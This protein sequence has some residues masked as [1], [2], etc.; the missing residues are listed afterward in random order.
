MGEEPPFFEEAVR[1]VDERLGSQLGG[2]ITIS[3][4]VTLDRPLID[5]V[6]KIDNR[7]FR[8]DLRYTVWDMIKRGE[9][10][11]FFLMMVREGK[12]P[13]AFFFGYE[14]DELPG[15]FYGDDMASVSEGKG[16]GG[17]LFTL[18]HIYCYENGYTHFSCHAE[19]VDDKGRRLRDWYKT[20]AGM[21]L[22]RVSEKEGDLLRVA[23]TPGHVNW[24]YH[25]H[26]LGEKG[27]KRATV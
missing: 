9:K 1:H 19:E 7:M 13:I 27:F 8:E 17:S 10:P 18:V 22:I 14:D 20:A 6:L 5:D 23:L 12:E 25:R 21:D 4:H 16:I 3:V 2:Q 11:G 15:G 24:M 26:I